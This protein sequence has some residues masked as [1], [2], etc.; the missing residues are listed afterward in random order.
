M[1]KGGSGAVLERPSTL[2]KTTYKDGG[3]GGGA[4]GGDG[5]DGGGNGKGSGGGGGG[6]AGDGGGSGPGDSRSISSDQKFTQIGIFSG[7]I[8]EKTLPADAIKRIETNP[9][10]KLGYIQVIRNFLDQENFPFKRAWDLGSKDL[11][12]Y[13]T[14]DQVL[15]H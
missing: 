8:L 3:G 7:S 11:M 10:A 13:L 14:M 15:D 2:S 9:F 1:Y 12:F 6:G 4:G 5:G